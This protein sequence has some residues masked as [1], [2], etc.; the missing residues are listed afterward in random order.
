MRDFGLKHYRNHPTDTYLSE[1][2]VLEAAD[3]T[4]ILRKEN[5]FRLD[6]KA[7]AIVEFLGHLTTQPHP[8][9]LTPLGFNGEEGGLLTEIYP[10]VDDS[11]LIPYSVR[12]AIKAEKLDI[13][14]VVAMM[15]QLTSALTYIHDLGY[16]HCDVRPNNIFLSTTE[17]ELHLTLFDYNNL[18]RPYFQEEPID[19]WLL[20][21]PPELAEGAVQIDARVDVY[22]LGRTLFDLTHTS[23][24]EVIRPLDPAHPVFEIMRQA[25]APL[26]DCYE[27]AVPMH[28]DLLLL[29]D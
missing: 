4:K 17:E 21:V 22:A 15:R 9:L 28:Q 10:L 11:L 12:E 25:Y 29:T 16:A 2:E 24:G 5:K 26:S 14:D 18:H 19:S 23:K 1:V 6:D 13:N 20:Q 3:G 7:M 8:H 27:S